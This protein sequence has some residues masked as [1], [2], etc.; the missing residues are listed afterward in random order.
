MG[1]DENRGNSIP[2]ERAMRI[3]IEP[4]LLAD[5][6]DFAWCRYLERQEA[7]RLLLKHGLATQE[8]IETPYGDRR[9]SPEEV[10]VD[11]RI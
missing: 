8:A 6:D 7:I 5:I 4:S 11:S 1:K 10:V 3:I 2:E 9:Q